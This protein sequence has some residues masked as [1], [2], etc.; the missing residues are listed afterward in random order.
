MKKMTNSTHLEGYLYSHNLELRVSGPQSKVPGTEFVKGT[1]DVLTD[2]ALNVVPVSFSYVTAKFNSGKP[3]TTFTTLM[4]IIKGELKNYVDAGTDAAKL[5]I[6][7]ALGLNDFYNADSELISYKINDGGFVHVIPTFGE[8]R[9]HFE[10]DMLITNV[11]FKEG[12]PDKETTDMVVVKGATFNFMGS[13]LPVDFTVREAGGMKFFQNLEVSNSEPIF[14]KV[15]G[16]ILCSTVTTE[17]AEAS[18]FGEDAV[19][20]S[21]RKLREWVITGASQEPYDFGDEAVLTSA[22]VVKA[23]TAREVHL[24]DTKARHDTY[25]A[26]KSSTPTAATPTAGAAPATK[27]AGFVF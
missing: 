25:L 15:W 5:R 6:D 17:T 11:V 8:P 24:A 16:K 9:N 27:A 4:N 3:N 19:K 21:T 20:V 18:A 14:M 12:D 7:T 10:V 26:S 2:D 1:L 23:M 13:L 22:D